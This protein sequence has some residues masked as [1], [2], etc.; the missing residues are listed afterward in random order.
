VLQSLKSILA[1]SSLQLSPQLFLG[2]QNIQL[3]Q[4]EQSKPKETVSCHYKIPEETIK[5]DKN[6][7]LQWAEHAATQSFAFDFTSIESQLNKLQSCYTE[8]GWIEF[9]SAMMKSGN[10]EAIKMQR[11]TM[12]SEVNGVAEFIETRENHWIIALPLK[13]TY[14]NDTMRVSQLLN[15]QLTVGRKTNGEFGVIQLIATLDPSSP[16]PS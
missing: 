16:P 7:I 13:V 6:I 5:T 15:I 8:N 9:N 2:S 3:K 10:I 12:T 4:P 11:L 14:K 1:S